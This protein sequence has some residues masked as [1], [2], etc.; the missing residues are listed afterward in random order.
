MYRGE[1]HRVSAS[2]VEGR[3]R[4]KPKS[5]SLSMGRDGRPTMGISE[6]LLAVRMGRM[7]L[8]ASVVAGWVQEQVLGF[9]IAVDEVALAQELQS[10]GELL[11]EVADHH[12][13][14][15]RVGRIRILPGHVVGYRVGDQ[16]IPL[17]DEQRE[18]A[19][20]AV[21]HDEVDV[22]GRLE[23]V[24]EAGDVGVSERL[25]DIDLAIE[26]LLELLVEAG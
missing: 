13:V 20:L 16:S 21:L 7:E 2:D 15:P 14:E 12:F 26:V 1:P 3:T 17:L 5:A 18:V 10:T 8:W 9:D 6:S 19:Q 23:A 24:V 22:C 11:Q 25:Q 4:A